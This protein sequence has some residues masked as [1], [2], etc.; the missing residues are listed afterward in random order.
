[1]ED[2]IESS[3]GDSVSRLRK[4]DD[5]DKAVKLHK[6][7]KEIEERDKKRAR[8]WKTESKQKKTPRNEVASIQI[9]AKDIHLLRVTDIEWGIF[10]RAC[11]ETAKKNGFKAPQHTEASPLRKAQYTVQRLCGMMRSSPGSFQ[12][13]LSEARA[14]PVLWLTGAKSRDEFHQLISSIKSANAI[15]PDKEQQD[16]FERSVEACSFMEEEARNDPERYSEKMGASPMGWPVLLKTDYKE[17]RPSMPE[18]VE[19]LS[20][21]PTFRGFD[22][23]KSRRGGAPDLGPTNLVAAKFAA[24]AMQLWGGKRL[25]TFDNPSPEVLKKRFKELTTSPGFPNIPGL[26]WYMLDPKETVPKSPTAQESIHAVWHLLESQT[27]GRAALIKE[28]QEIAGK[29]PVGE[30]KSAAKRR[31]CKALASRIEQLKP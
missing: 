16:T 14:L 19:L 26:K 13:L 2:D 22:F 28:F 24:V 20:N 7:L 4:K 6:V 30:T 15:P 25:L 3:E 12:G 9:E 17:K 23:Y 21:Q 29:V 11:Y 1:M 10:R 27:D 31:I 5:F 18:V 8:G